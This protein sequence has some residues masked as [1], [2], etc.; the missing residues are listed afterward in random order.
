MLLKKGLEQ[1]TLTVARK[2][3]HKQELHADSWCV[4]SIKDGVVVADSHSSNG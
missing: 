2:R 4:L 3:T 1:E